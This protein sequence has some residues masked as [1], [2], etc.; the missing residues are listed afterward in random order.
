[1]KTLIKFF[2][3]SALL[4]LVAGLQNTYAQAASFETNTSTIKTYYVIDTVSNS[5]GVTITYPYTVPAGWGY[6]IQVV[7]DSLSGSTAGTISVKTTAGVTTKVYKTITSGTAT[8][9]G[10]QTIALWESST[11]TAP[12]PGT[13]IQVA[14]S[15][16]G[17]QSTKIRCWITLKKLPLY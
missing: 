3:I 8:V 12:W 9:D 4:L 1:M 10:L 7:A 16:G 11:T 5:T 2:F 14:V 15:G 17:T 13:G 6:C